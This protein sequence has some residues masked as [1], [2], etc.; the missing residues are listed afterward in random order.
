MGWFLFVYNT[1]L[2][3]RFFLH[4]RLLWQTILLCSFV[5]VCYV[6]NWIQ[7]V[8]LLILISVR[9]LV[10]TY[11]LCIWFL[12]RQSLDKSP[13]SI[14]AFVSLKII[15]YGRWLSCFKI[16][17]WISYEMTFSIGHFSVYKCFLYLHIVISTM[18]LWFDYHD[19]LRGSKKG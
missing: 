4:D 7:K 13:V 12:I 14:F 3:Q 19:W 6:L 16:L 18:T 2:R 11:V 5:V 8:F 17:I 9:L 1:F 15:C 10:Y